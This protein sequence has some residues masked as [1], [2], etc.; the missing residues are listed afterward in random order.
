LVFSLTPIRWLRKSAAGKI[1]TEKI[2][3]T[4]RL[5]FNQRLDAAV[6]AVLASMILVLIVEALVQ[7]YSILSHRKQPVLHESSYVANEVGRKF[8]RRGTKE[9]D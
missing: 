7:W 6:T 1:P 8:H 3:E 5:I 2:A 9:S 4:Q